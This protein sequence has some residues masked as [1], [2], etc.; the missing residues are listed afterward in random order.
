MELQLIRQWLNARYT[1]GKLS[2]NGVFQCYTLE[3]AVREYKIPG[4]TAIPYGRY[5]VVINESK[6]FGRQLP[7]LLNVPNFS[8][9]RI[10]PGNGPKDTEGCILVGMERGDG[11]ISSSQIAMDALMAKLRTAKTN[12]Y[13]SIERGEYAPGI[14]GR[15]DT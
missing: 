2:V 11:S 6:R 5:E 14:D 8:G 1:I 4:E 15:L 3:D 12:I 13:I 10:H 7:L 9:V